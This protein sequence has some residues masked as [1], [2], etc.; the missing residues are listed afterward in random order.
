MIA[1][2]DGEFVADSYENGILQKALYITWQSN[3]FSWRAHI[4]DKKKGMRPKAH[5]LIID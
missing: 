2:G 3:T 5:P 1:L 4:D